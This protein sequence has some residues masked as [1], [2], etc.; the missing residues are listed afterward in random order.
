ML[1]TRAS[2][3]AAP[4][5]VALLA[6]TACSG[7]A[8][9][10][11]PGAGSSDSSGSSEAAAVEVTDNH[12]T[13]EVDQDYDSVI[14]T[15]NRSFRILEELGVELSAAPR[16]LMADEVSYKDD[17][18]IL[19]MG[20]HREPDLE[21]VVAAEPDLII[22]GQRFAQHRE[23][24]AE[25]APE[26]TLLEFDPRDG[27]PFDQ[28]L[29][30]QVEALGTVFGEEEAAAG[31]VEDFE[32]Q[33]DRAREA[34]DGESST[35]GLLT[36]GGDISY[37]APT[38][39]RAIGPVFD[40][41][42]LE[43]A[44]EQTGEDESHGDDISVEAIAAA[45]P[46]WLLVLDRDAQIA[47]GEDDYT[48]A[49]ELI[50]ESEALQDVPAVEEDQIVHLPANFYTTEDIQAYTEFFADFADALESAGETSGETSDESEESD[51]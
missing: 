48:P 40:I 3:S 29:I 34:Y 12:G 11:D 47:A 33:I 13:H 38:T 9:A 39:G 19:D 37:V 10:D 31:L 1:V 50:E 14:A 46:E 44:L 36:S 49:A 16:Q 17:E 27:E 51:Q 6:L 24:I 35:M 20:L 28:E 15:D 4:A 25:L 21:Q 43:P 18:S 23:D 5:A 22:N 41:L 26:A 8:S 42:G 7:Q 45:E 32:A 2:R 30:R